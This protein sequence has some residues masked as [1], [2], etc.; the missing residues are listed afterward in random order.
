MLLAPFHILCLETSATRRLREAWFASTCQ[1]KPSHPSFSASQ[2]LCLS[3]LLNTGILPSTQVAGQSFWP[4][5]LNISIRIHWT[6]TNPG[7]FS[8]RKSLKRQFSADR[9]SYI[10]GEGSNC[11]LQHTL[12]TEKL[13]PREQTSFYCTREWTSN[14]ACTIVHEV[15]KI[16]LQSLGTA[17]A[18]MHIEKGVASQRGRVNGVSLL[19]IW[20]TGDMN[21]WAVTHNCYSDLSIIF[22]SSLQK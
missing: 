19:C 3:Y 21:P 15:H 12:E 18:L 16:I 1:G 11:T 7:H 2:A 13:L 8:T 20:R 5:Q 14:A 4:F 17:P 22:I 9:L 6:F 10:L